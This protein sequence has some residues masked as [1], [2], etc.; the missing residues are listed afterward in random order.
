MKGTTTGYAG[1]PLFLGDREHF[2]VQVDAKTDQLFIGKPVK[3]R[4]SGKMSIQLSRRLSKPDGSFDGVIVASIDPEFVEQFHRSMKLG[5]YS[6][7]ALLGLDGVAR[8]F[9]G[10]SAPADNM[11]E[12]VSDAL[13]R[14]PE[15]Y[16]WSDGAFD[17][18]NRLVSYR[19]I[20]EYPLLVWIGETERHVFAEYKRQRMI[21]FAIAAFLTL[22]VLIAVGNK[23]RR[24]QSSQ[25]MTRRFN[26]ALENMSLGLCMFDAAQRLII[27]N[28]QYI[29]LYGLNGEQIK[30]GMTLREILEQRI[31]NGK[32]PGDHEGYIDSLIS[33]V[34]SNK[35]YQTTYRLSDGRYISVVHKPMEGGGWV[36]THEDIT[37][38]ASRAEQEKRRAEIDAAIIAFRENV[39]AILLSV[40]K[41]SATLHEIS[42][43][44]S[45]SCH[46]ASDEAAGAVQA[47]NKAT[48]N[49]GSAATAAVELDSSITEINQQLNQAAD[50]ARGAVSEAQATNGEI[51]GMAQA[52]QKIGSILKLIQDIAEQTNLLA[53]NATI[54]AARAGPAGSG[55]AVVAAE[56]KSLSV[57]TAKAT[58]EIAAQILAVQ[59]STDSAVEAIQKI[60]E[61]MQEID[62]Y[63]SSV[64]VSV[65][66]QSA[67]TG[68]ISRH[69]MDAAKETKVVV[70]ILER[71][72][73]AITKTDSSAGKVLTASRAVEAEAANL[74]TKIEA[75][76]RKVAA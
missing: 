67:A 38:S 15:G 31:A 1:A 40:D 17:G 22:F 53:L 51:G 46:S 25:Q 58:E 7:I 73:G 35:P 12:K 45:T 11:P 75:F 61:R 71:V 54:E 19:T 37:E 34:T 14:T 27:C 36:A 32:A 42:T 23:I 64:A 29:E 65:G 48:S 39:E 20:A 6:S 5:E 24:Q 60:T 33:V 59:G 30:P 68:E 52:A 26:V 55:F 41:C 2:K 74:R 9:H 66:H 50:V 49:V 21:Y 43:E 76:L 44:L 28:K 56:V 62:K 69:V 8:A 4:A 10:L 47:S 63:T 70:S 72:V 3:G 13:A 18:T 57:E 16:F